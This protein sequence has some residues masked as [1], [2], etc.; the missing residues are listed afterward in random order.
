MAPK[1]AV[2]KSAALVKEAVTPA[3]AEQKAT[4]KP[5]GRPRA[6]RA[7]A[8]EEEVAPALHT[9]DIKLPVITFHCPHIGYTAAFCLRAVR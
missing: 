8:P 5:S 3:A 6:K 4:K 9:P 1:K 2:K 7:A